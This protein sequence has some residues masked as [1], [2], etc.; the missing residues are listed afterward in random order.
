M[1]KDAEQLALKEFQK[2]PGVGKKI[3]EY[4]TELL[5]WWNWKDRVN[6]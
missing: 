4:D 1:V 5:K 2:I 6:G 3:D